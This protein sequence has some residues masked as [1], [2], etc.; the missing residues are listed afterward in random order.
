MRELADSIKAFRTQQGFTQAD[1]ATRAR[2]STRTIV[3]I[4]NETLS[5][6]LQPKVIIK[7]AAALGRDPKRWLELIGYGIT[8]DQIDQISKRSNVLL[9]NSIKSDAYFETLA[10]A[11]SPVR[12]ALLC[13]TFLSKIGLWEKAL[14]Q[15]ALSKLVKESNL[16]LA[17]IVPFPPV[18]INQSPKVGLA[19]Y[20][21]SI[22][23]DVMELTKDLLVSLPADKKNK[24]GLFFPSV[25]HSDFF[26][27]PHI[28]HSLVRSTLVKFFRKDGT[29]DFL[30]DY[31]L[32]VWGMSRP[33][34]EDRWVK[35]FPAVEPMNQDASEEMLRYWLSYLQEIVENYAP[36]KKIPWDENLGCWK[37]F[38]L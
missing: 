19:T 17:I 2:M 31:Q 26:I 22:T 21:Q 10:G 4:E 24:V 12:S 35:I 23:G 16:T 15:S 1:L 25:S 6:K 38:P 7:I 29:T 8:Q 30:T 33:N 36:H 32:G 13:I 28:T 18:D 14:I 9:P 11:L 37:K 3:A 34:N 20:Y 5:H 27:P